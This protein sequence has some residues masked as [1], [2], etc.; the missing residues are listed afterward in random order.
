MPTLVILHWCFNYLLQKR[1]WK[2]YKMSNEAWSNLKKMFQFGHRKK[3]KLFSPK[4]G[5]SI[6]RRTYAL[7][8]M[9]TMKMKSKLRRK[10][11]RKR[12]HRASAA[13]V[14]TIYLNFSKKDFHVFWS[15]ASGRNKQH[16]RKQICDQPELGISTTT[17]KTD[18]K[19]KFYSGYSTKT[20]GMSPVKIARFVEIILWFLAW[21]WNTVWLD[22]RGTNS[23]F[24]RYLK[25]SL[26][27]SWINKCYWTKK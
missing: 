14:M 6:Q 4:S 10:W 15:S 27:F 26:C 21:N 8:N 24:N 1:L 12:L 13:D 5:E 3:S 17:A 16:G 2:H 9:Y 25:N 20:N 19:K 22:T 11:V 23:G 7:V 18:V